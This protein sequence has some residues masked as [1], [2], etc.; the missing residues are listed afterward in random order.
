MIFVMTLSTALLLAFTAVQASPELLK[1]PPLDCS[2]VFCAVPV[3]AENEERYTP[4]GKCCSQCRPLDCSSVACLDPICL[5]NEEIFTPPGQCCNQCRP[6]VCLADC[7]DPMCLDSEEYYTPPG[8]CCQQCRP[9]GCSLEQCVLPMCLDGQKL[10]TTPG[11]CCPT[12]R[13]IGCQQGGILYEN[14]DNVPSTSKPLDPCERCSC[15]DETIV[16]D[17]LFCPDCAGF[18]PPGACCPICGTFPGELA[19]E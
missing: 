11:K 5:N 16:C 6:K 9:A 14:G 1:R 19:T 7:L 2:L 3:C 13:L 4:P 17:H 18:K 12:C 8:E 15:L 10:Y